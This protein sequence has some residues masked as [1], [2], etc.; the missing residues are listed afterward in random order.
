[1]KSLEE[2][3][4]IKGRVDKPEQMIQAWMSDT[5]SKEIYSARIAFRDTFDYEFIQSY[6]DKYLPGYCDR[7]WLFLSDELREI[8]SGYEKVVV[9]GAGQRGKAL[10]VMLKKAG[11]PIM[12]A[13]DNREEDY[14]KQAGVPI[15]KPENTDYAGACVIVSPAFD[16]TTAALSEQLQRI[17]VKP[18]HVYPLN[19]YV[20]GADSLDEKQYFDE[21][22][23]N[24]EPEEVF[25]DCGVY[26]LGTSIRFAGNCRAHG[27]E[28]ITVHAFEPDRENYRI[29][30]DK[31]AELEKEGVSV[32]LY[33]FGV[34]REDGRLLFE[35][36]GGSGSKITNNQDS[37]DT[38]DVVALDSVIREKVTFIKMD[39][40]GA[41]LEA[42]K[43]AKNLIQT[44]RPKL[45]ICIY[46]KPEDL[47]EIP[48]YIKGLVPDYKLYVRHYSNNTGELVLYAVI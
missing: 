28:K 22:I 34:W 35:A 20:C 5:Q 48:L 19:D 11:F 31:K 46:H 47:T 3:T 40:E 9:A 29:C 13:V 17:G 21:D 18:E 39:I 8:L 12:A 10:I 43:G 33:P 15:V 4:D 23:L 37:A 24:W 25:V 30:S 45:A 42:L 38:I 26:D 32:T 41:E 14:F 36:G 2:M 6:L 1:M 44:Y 27:V 7:K 16:T